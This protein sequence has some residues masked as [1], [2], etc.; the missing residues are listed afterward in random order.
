MQESLSSQPLAARDGV[1]AAPPPRPSLGPF[2]ARES[3]GSRPS[4]GGLV[5]RSGIRSFVS[6]RPSLLPGAPS[7]VLAPNDIDFHS[8]RQ[9]TARVS[10]PDSGLLREL[11]H[12]GLTWPQAALLIVADVLG[13]GVLAVPGGFRALGWVA[14]V[15]VLAACYPV[16]MYT[17]LLLERLRRLAPTSITLGD[18]ADAT[19]GRCGG[20][21]GRLFLYVYLQ[22]ILGEYLV[23]MGTSLQ[24]VF[25]RSDGTQQLSLLAS[26]GITAGLLLFPNQIR[27]LENVTLLCVMSAVAMVLAIGLTLGQIVSSGCDEITSG[28]AKSYGQFWDVLNA[29]SSF[30]LACSGQFIYLEMMSEMSEPKKFAYSLH[31]ATPALVLLYFLVA[32]VTYGYCGDST[33]SYLLDAIPA[34]TVK[35]VVG[36]LLYAHTLVSYTI[37]QQ[38]LSRNIHVLLDPR[39]AVILQRGEAGYWCSRVQWL[40][41]TTAH[42]GIAFAFAVGVSNFENISHLI[43]ALMVAPLCFVLPCACLLMVPIDLPLFTRTVWESGFAW[44]L[45]IFTALLTMI[46]TV[47]ALLPIVK[48][49]DA[50]A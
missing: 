26:V 32:G 49:L 11:E 2:S 16:N 19:I 27:S 41:I 28:P 36:V 17:G 5:Q 37:N 3:L 34:C 20:I 18:L 30:L 38:V 42:L 7:E 22:S 13:T 44:L 33:P 15:L 48:P 12:T 29:I 14:G 6:V 4:L 9:S 24:A 43:G 47:A 10:I 40:A 8:V 45:M 1:S 46:G 35:C 23:V 21:V 39:R 50:S 31:L 25:A